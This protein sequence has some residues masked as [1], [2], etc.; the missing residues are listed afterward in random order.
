[1]SPVNWAG[2]VSGTNHL[3]SVVTRNFSPVNELRYQ[4]GYCS[5]GKFQLGYRD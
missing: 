3:G 5:Y 1:M 4:P 2:S